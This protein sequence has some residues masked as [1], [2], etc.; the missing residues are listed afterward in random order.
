MMVRLL[1]M[2]CLIMTMLMPCAWAE[3][4]DASAS[5]LSQ[6]TI[7]AE[8]WV[9][10]DLY[11]IRYTFT[12]PTDE[13]IDE[14]IDFAEIRYDYHNSTDKN[15]LGQRT[16]C[17]ETIS[18][19]TI[20]P[21]SSSTIIVSLKQPFP[22]AFNRLIT[23][24]FYFKDSYYLLHSISMLNMPKSPFSLLPN[25][26]PSGDVSLMIRNDSPTETITEL[27]K[28]LILLNIHGNQYYT[29]HAE[30]SSLTIKPNETKTIPLLM[31]ENAKNKEYPHISF[32]ISMDING[33]QHYYNDIV[34]TP[35]TLEVRFDSYYSRSAIPQISKDSV[36]YLDESNLYAYIQ[37]QGRHKEPISASNIYYILDLDILTKRMFTNTIFLR[38][39]TTRLLSE[40][41]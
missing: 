20:A 10:G 28:I 4:K 33:I 30:P 29:L 24:T 19:L 16:Q 11:H 7:E 9:E 38:L 39:S 32:C 22:S 17:D 23:S 1:M 31:P 2:I 18:R 40:D 5:P 14:E 13:M 36:F 27:S 15:N 37:V 3:E 12:N 21:H 25:V 26:S 8:D 6:V 41:R 35:D 34:G